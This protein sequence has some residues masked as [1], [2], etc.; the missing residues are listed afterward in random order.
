M[1]K[2]NENSHWPFDRH[3]VRISPF[4][5]TKHVEKNSSASYGRDL[6]VGV[7]HPVT[8]SIKKSEIPRPAPIQVLT[9]LSVA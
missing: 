1:N 4:H 2:I 7:V 6:V 3:H 8:G 9:R 5:N